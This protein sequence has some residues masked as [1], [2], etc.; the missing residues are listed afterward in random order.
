MR[1]RPRYCAKKIV[2][3]RRS[4]VSWRGAVKKENFRCR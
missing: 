3:D 2:R 1:R 4:G